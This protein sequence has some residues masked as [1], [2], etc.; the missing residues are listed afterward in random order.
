MDYG[1]LLSTIVCIMSIIEKNDHNR[2][3]EN[4]FPNDDDAMQRNIIYKLKSNTYVEYV[5]LIASI[6]GFIRTFIS[7]V[8]K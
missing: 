6:L 2:K 8:V 4:L 3:L 1:Y 7:T 5:L